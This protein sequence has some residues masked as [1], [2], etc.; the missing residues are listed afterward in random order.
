[1]LLSKEHSIA[2]LHS[3]KSYVETKSE[4]RSLYRGLTMLGLGTK[5]WCPSQ[6]GT[7]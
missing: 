4:C 2:Y 5:Y 1:M 6:V 3:L 7:E